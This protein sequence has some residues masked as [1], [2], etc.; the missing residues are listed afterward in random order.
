MKPRNLVFKH[1]RKTAKP[2][3]H[4]DRKRAQKSGYAKHKL[5]SKRSDLYT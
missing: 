1:I 4:T 2:M 5:D 3:V